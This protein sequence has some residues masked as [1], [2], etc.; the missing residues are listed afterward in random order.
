MSVNAHSYGEKGEE[1]VS[2][3]EWRKCQL[4]WTG[5]LRQVSCVDKRKECRERRERREPVRQITPLV[6]RHLLEER[7]QTGRNQT[8]DW[9]QRT[10]C[11]DSHDNNSNHNPGWRVCRCRIQVQFCHL[12]FFLHV[13]FFTLVIRGKWL[14]FFRMLETIYCSLPKRRCTRRRMSFLRCF[15]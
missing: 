13:C 1:V 5:P 12:F 7:S 15:F 2:A 9:Q 8:I 11:K 14:L 6:S 10:H 4:P 3:G